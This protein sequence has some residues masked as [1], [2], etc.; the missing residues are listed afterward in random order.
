V[1][2]AARTHPAALVAQGDTSQRR[3]RWRASGRLTPCQSVLIL[4]TI[5][6]WYLQHLAVLAVASL[7]A[8]A[9]IGAVLWLPARVWVSRRTVRGQRYMETHVAGNPCNTQE[10]TESPGNSP[11]VFAMPQPER[12]DWGGPV[13]FASVSGFQAAMDGIWSGCFFEEPVVVLDETH[14]MIRQGP[15]FQAVIPLKNIA[16]VS[17]ASAWR[18]KMRAKTVYFHVKN[19]R[20]LTV[21]LKLDPPTEVLRRKARLVHRVILQVTD[22]E[23]LLDALKSAIGIA[24]S[25]PSS[26]PVW[27]TKLA[28]ER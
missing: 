1:G 13:P 25:L 4:G 27:R 24:P 17:V 15:A 23:K 20:Y 19:G 18:I 22:T 11:L 3:R 7:V 12:P 5:V 14:L 8:G 28:R 26:D 9:L 6:P 10:P 16:N 21:S 2:R